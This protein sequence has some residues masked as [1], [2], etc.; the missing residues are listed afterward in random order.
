MINI[1]V[2]GGAGFI[3]SHMISYLLKFNKY[4]I[5]TIDNLSSG[6]KKNI[7]KNVNI[8]IGDC[9]D[10]KFINSI[11]TKF[12]IIIHL[13]AQSGGEGSF[14]D[15]IYD[16]NT[17]AKATLVLLNLA[18]R[19]SCKRFIFMS[20]VAIYGGINNIEKYSEKSPI[21]PHTFYAINKLTSEYYLKLYY[22]NYKI[23]YT[24][25][26]LFNCYGPNQNLN[27]MKQGIV[28]IYLKQFIDNN[29]DKVIIKGSLDRIRDLIHVDDVV[30][31]TYD[32]I[33]NK[34]FFN[35]IFNLATGKPTTVK[36]L[37]EK[38]KK[39]GKFKKDYIVKGKTPGDMNKIYA[40]ID[41]LNK[42]YNTYNFITLDKG[43]QYI[44]H[45]V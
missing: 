28:S 8:I 15:V 6:Y 19:V 36:E 26:R 38:I 30:T 10:E 24:I 17:N 45:I 20:T 43:L 23:D 16:I 32:S 11:N 25:F 33:Y 1:L 22:E 31:I 39:I 12:D 4:N 13:A 29:Y 18:R 41:K 42:I 2:T 14:D 5:T 21:D 7:P 3:G 9:S 35:N 37:L 27:N 44:N 34:N 40:N